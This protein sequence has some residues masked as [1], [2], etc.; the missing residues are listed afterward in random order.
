MSNLYPNTRVWYGN[1]LKPGYC[2]GPEPE[3]GFSLA[4]KALPFSQVKDALEKTLVNRHQPPKP[5]EPKAKPPKPS[6]EWGGEKLGI[7]KKD[8]EI[9]NKQGLEAACSKEDRKK[10]FRVQ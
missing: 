6:W 1:N 3:A 9:W 7:S 5:K 2:G 10:K 8:W 4:W